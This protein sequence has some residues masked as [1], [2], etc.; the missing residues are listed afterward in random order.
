MR[1]IARLMLLS[2][3][4]AG[5][6]TSTLPVL[7]QG[8]G[9]IPPGAPAGLQGY[10]LGTGDH[11]SVIV[12]GEDKISGPTTIDP[13]GNITLPLAGSIVAAGKTIAELT[14]A[15]RA[16]LAAGYMRQPSV[17]VQVLSFRPYYI[18]GEVNKP[19]E[20]EYSNGLTVMD[21]IAVAQGFTYRARKSTVFVTHRGAS[22]EQRIAVTPGLA[23][24]PGDTIRVGERY[25]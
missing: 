25:F 20:Y 4:L 19:G 10:R 12:Y 7:A 8:T 9:A 22:V 6:G 5:L 23:V 15:I 16:A 3:M 14:E 11:L 2:G 21:A 13:E 17:A 1:R 24:V 18:L